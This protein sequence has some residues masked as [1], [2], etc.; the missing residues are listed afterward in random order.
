MLHRRREADG[1]SQYKIEEFDLRG[2]ISLG[3]SKVSTG[4]DMH[5][6][7]TQRSPESQYLSNLKT[8]PLHRA[9]LCM[10]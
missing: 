4:Y 6:A 10:I 5:Q 3:D 8:D 1:F 7:T 9:L 2:K